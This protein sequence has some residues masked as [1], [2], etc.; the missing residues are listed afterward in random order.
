MMTTE[1]TLFLRD[2]KI[3]VLVDRAQAAEDSLRDFL[4]KRRADNEAWWEIR[5][6]TFEGVIRRSRR[7]AITGVA[8]ALYA[9]GLMIAS[10][11]WCH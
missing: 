1:E 3:E 9:T 5:E 6:R 7:L 8:A 2:A 4:D 10:I 11:I